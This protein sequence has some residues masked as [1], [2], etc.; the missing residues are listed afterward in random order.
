MALV[1][2]SSSS[3]D[4]SDNEQV[5]QPP[6]APPSQPTTAKSD[7]SLLTKRKRTANSDDENATPSQGKTRKQDHD[8]SDSPA[9][10]TGYHDLVTT[11]PHTFHDPT[12]H[13]GRKRQTPH[14]E[15]NWPSHV[16]LL[17]MYRS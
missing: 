5:S 2:Y 17:C 8:R 14:V 12:L 13:G 16:Y 10:P 4:E 9:F 11:T 3:D 7:Q 1:D 15:G 6:P